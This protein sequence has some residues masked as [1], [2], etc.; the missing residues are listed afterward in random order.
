LRT[1]QQEFTVKTETQETAEL[2][3]LAYNADLKQ[4]LIEAE[5][6]SATQLQQLAE[7]RQ[8]T[9]IDYIQ[10]HADVSNDQLKRSE[11]VATR[12]EDGWLKLKFELVTL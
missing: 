1:L 11:T 4:R 3:V 5:S 2:D 9:I 7:Q 10:Q 6:I 12:L 8:Q